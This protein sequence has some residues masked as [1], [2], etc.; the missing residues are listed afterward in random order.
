V[1]FTSALAFL[2]G[3]LAVERGLWG[4]IPAGVAFLF[5]L[6]REVVKD[7]EDM[8]ADGQRR[9][10][11]WPLVVGERGARLSAAI[12]LLLLAVVL[13]LPWAAGWLG[14]WYLAI[15][16]AGVGVPALWLAWGLRR[17]R[18]SAGYGRYAVIL[19]WDMLVGLAAVLVG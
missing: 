19:K 11:T 6:A 3:S 7:L 10:R 17:P 5:H 8:E 9:L 15:A 16:V 4:L 12:T 13:P 2:F 14:P 18:E 1:A